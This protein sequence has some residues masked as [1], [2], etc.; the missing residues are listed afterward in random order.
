MR[1]PSETTGT[2]LNTG[3]ICVP[4]EDKKKRHEKIFEEIMVENFT[5]MGKEI[6]QRV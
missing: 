1:T 3:I 4:K 2:M 5:K 6:A